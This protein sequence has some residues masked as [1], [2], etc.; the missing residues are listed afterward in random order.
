MSDPYSTGYEESAPQEQPQPRRA[1]RSV[2]PA[3]ILI[4]GVNIAVYAMMAIRGVDPISPDVRDLL[5]WGANFGPLSL[6]SE[7]WRLL[8]STVIHSGL[9]HIFFNMWALWQLGRATESLF[10]TTR[11]FIFYIFAGIGGSLA[12]SLWHPDIVSVGAS[13]AIF[14][15]VGALTGFILKKR[16]QLAPDVFQ[17]QLKSMLSIVGYNIVF[18]FVIPHVDNSAHMGGLITGLLFG[19]LA[20]ES[21]GF[22]GKSRSS[23]LLITLGLV[24]LLAS[25]GVFAHTK[26]LKTKPSA[27]ASQLTMKAIPVGA[28]TLRYDPGISDVV[29]N[30]FG[31]ALKASGNGLSKTTI[32]LFSADPRVEIGL[33]I[34]AKW[35]NSDEATEEFN[36]FAL[37]MSKNVF[38]GKPVDVKLYDGMMNELRTITWKDSNNVA[39][40]PEP[41]APK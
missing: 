19:Y 29:A 22:R 41:A 13:G 9:A 32:L 25:V 12:S 16:N 26:A 37:S 1:S 10:G 5:K 17:S 31:D 3:L 18:G 14:G 24:G 39:T 15:I 28:A 7:P 34:Q 8:S 11:F 33:L 4:L 35:A 40:S 6:T 36:S 21:P 20:L 2:G 38:N 27:M 23:E 30:R